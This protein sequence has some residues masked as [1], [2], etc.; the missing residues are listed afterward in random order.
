MAND[1]T[2]DETPIGWI[3]LVDWGGDDNDRDFFGYNKDADFIISLGGN[4][5]H[6]S[7]Q[8]MEDIVQAYLE[9]KGDDK[10]E[11]T[12]DDTRVDKVVRTD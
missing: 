3:V 2:H 5:V 6:L 9:S 1:H 7:H 4:S 12:T 11:T 10:N 8:Q